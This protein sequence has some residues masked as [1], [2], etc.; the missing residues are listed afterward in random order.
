MPAPEIP[1]LPVEP[2]S[3]PE[4]LASPPQGPTASSPQPEPALLPTLRSENGRL[5]LTADS[6]TI[7]GQRYSLL[8]LEGVEV[9]PVRWLLWFM[10][11]GLVLAGFTLAFLQNWLRTMPA[12]FGMALGALILAYGNR[13]ANRLRLFRLGREAAYFS[14][15]GASEQWLKLAAEANRRIRQRHDEAAAAAAAVLQAELD[16]SQPAPDPADSPIPS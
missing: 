4:P 11:G 13:G 8:E 12:M 3:A 5:E 1:E 10:L 9:Q 2:Q 16:A 14:F 6:L 15:S 7:E